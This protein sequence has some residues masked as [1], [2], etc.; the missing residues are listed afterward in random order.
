M[1]VV[2]FINFQEPLLHIGQSLVSFQAGSYSQPQLE[3]FIFII[4]SN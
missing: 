3:H 2:V 1:L 4:L